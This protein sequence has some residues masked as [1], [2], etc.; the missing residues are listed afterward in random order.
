V[1]LA[2]AA[3]DGRIIHRERRLGEAGRAAVRRTCV[4]EALAMLSELAGQLAPG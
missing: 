3:A 1:H 4:K 2:A